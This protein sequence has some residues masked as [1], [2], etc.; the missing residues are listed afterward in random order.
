ML[1][2]GAKSWVRFKYECLPSLCFWCGRLDHSDKNCELWLRSKGSLTL[3][4]QQFNSDLK[5]TL[6]TSTGRDVIVV[7]GFYENKSP[8][9]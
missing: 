6:Y 5:A 8:F 7:L 4:Q 2:N 3:D 9:T 1:E